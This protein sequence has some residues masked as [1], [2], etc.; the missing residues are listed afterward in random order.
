MKDLDRKVVIWFMLA[1]GSKCFPS[2]RLRC[3]WNRFMF[4]EEKAILKGQ[5]MDCSPGYLQ[6]HAALLLG[7]LFE[8]W[9]SI[10]Y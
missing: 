6:W 10:S 2:P 3:M 9:L 4:G 7:A 1:Q 5:M 8:L